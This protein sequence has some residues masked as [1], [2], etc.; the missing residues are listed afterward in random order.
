[1]L[2]SSPAAREGPKRFRFGISGSVSAV[3][4]APRFAADSV[5]QGFVRAGF[6]IRW[7]WGCRKTGGRVRNHV[8]FAH[9]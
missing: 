5:C 6:S 2:K 7:L 3:R 9:C 1:M 8:N 4:S